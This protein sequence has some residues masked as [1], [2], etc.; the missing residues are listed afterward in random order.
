MVLFFDLVKKPPPS[1]PSS[2]RCARLKTV[3]FVIV[4]LCLGLKNEKSL[5]I[6]FRNWDIFDVFHFFPQRAKINQEFSS[7]FF[8]L[9]LFIFLLSS[10]HNISFF[11][12]SSQKT[13][14]QK[15]AKKNKSFK[16]CSQILQGFFLFLF[17]DDFSVKRI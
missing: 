5:F 3:V 7:V 10:N 17:S 4:F 12:S 16:C 1:P 11:F 6:F 15:L 14:W 13:K 2:S 9:S 8:S